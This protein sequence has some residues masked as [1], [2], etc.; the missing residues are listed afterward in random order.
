MHVIFRIARQRAYSNSD[1]VYRL[2]VC[3][4]MEWHGAGK[5]KPKEPATLLLHIRSNWQ[6]CALLNKRLSISTWCCSNASRTVCQATGAEQVL[7]RK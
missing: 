1:Q 7:V 4:L 6:R 3:M 5:V 2:L